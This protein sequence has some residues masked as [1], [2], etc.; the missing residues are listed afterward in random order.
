MDPKREKNDIEVRDD[1]AIKRNRMVFDF[2]QRTFNHIDELYMDEN[3]FLID[4]I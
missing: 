3:I 2:M 1:D 4:A